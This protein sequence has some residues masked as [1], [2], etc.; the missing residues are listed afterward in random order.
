M[1][2][3]GGAFFLNP[4]CPL[5]R[6]RNEWESGAKAPH[7]ISPRRAKVWHPTCCHSFDS[8]HSWLSSPTPEPFQVTHAD[9]ENRPTAIHLPFYFPLR[10]GVSQLLISGAMF[11]FPKTMATCKST[12]ILFPKQNRAPATQCSDI[13]LRPRRTPR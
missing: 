4:R 12:S 6:C 2:R 5:S 10:L 3:L 8:C 11:A 13:F 7:S 9:S 1:L